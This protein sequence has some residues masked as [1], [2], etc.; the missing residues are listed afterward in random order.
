MKTKLLKKNKLAIVPAGII[1][2]TEAFWYNN[3]KWVVHEGRSARFHEA[4]GS[5]QRMIAEAFM[6]DKRS[7]NYLRKTGITSFSEGFEMWYKCVIG[8]IDHV[9]DFQNGI[10]TPDG[11]NNACNDHSCPHRG[12]LCSL[13][14]GLKNYEVAT[15]VALKK[16]KSIEETAYW[17]CISKAGMKSR[18]EK[19][20][21]KLGAA[22]IASMMSLATEMGI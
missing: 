14:A 10:L 3:E 18:V 1:E 16:G 9:S 12:K 11:F 19:I 7:Q 8:G 5:V 17:L 22:N 20:K 6:N 21:Q 2:G 15:I 13:E 4:P